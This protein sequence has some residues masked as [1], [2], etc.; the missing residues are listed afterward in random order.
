MCAHAEFE[1]TRKALSQRRNNGV[2]NPLRL[3]GRNRGSNV[4]SVTDVTSGL[5]CEVKVEYRHLFP[6]MRHTRG[7]RKVEEKGAQVQLRTPVMQE[8]SHLHL[9]KGMFDVCIKA[10]C[11]YYRELPNLSHYNLYIYSA[12]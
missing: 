12:I 2:Y 6:Q 7:W 4:I 9:M 5:W 3:Y 10:L 8:G 1:E 11:V